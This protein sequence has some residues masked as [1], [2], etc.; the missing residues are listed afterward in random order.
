MNRAITVI[1]GGCLNIILDIILEDQNEHFHGTIQ[2]S[3]LAER[4]SSVPIYPM[5]L[6]PAVL[7][8]LLKQGIVPG[9]RMVNNSLQP[10]ACL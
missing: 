1:L 6:P 2:S 4:L 7:Y 9:P 8:R 10:G 3:I 5:T